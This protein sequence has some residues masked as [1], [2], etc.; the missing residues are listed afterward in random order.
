MFVLNILCTITINRS[1]FMQESTQLIQVTPSI[2]LNG[3]TNKLEVSCTFQAGDD[4]NLSS[5]TSLGVRL[6]KTS[7]NQQELA[8]VTSFN[9][10]SLSGNIS[11][12]GAIDNTGESYLNLTWQSPDSTHLGEYICVATVLDLTG[13][14]LTT[15]VA[16]NVTGV[17][18]ESELL[19][20][21]IVQLKKV[22]NKLDQELKELKE[23][24]SV[25]IATWMGRVNAMKKTL[26]ETSTLFNGSQYF[27]YKGDIVVDPI[28]AQ[29]TC[30]TYGGNLVEITDHNEFDFVKQF[31]LDSSDAA[32][33][34][35]GGNQVNELQNLIYPHSNVSVTYF[36]WAE[37]YPI[38]SMG[39]SCLVLWGSSDFNM[40]NINCLNSFYMRYICENV[41]V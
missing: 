9:G 11:A 26:F 4:P 41:L 20:S 21:E 8:S 40:T 24:I 25:F 13:H 19:I 33:V 23:N 18:P 29:A 34:L 14:P 10:V 2:L 31:I 27:I 28:Q 6:L 17:N 3:L 37:H 30:E 15:S 39:A 1:Q 12:S 36:R 5:L 16:A 38:F 32:L 7:A 22:N 35:I